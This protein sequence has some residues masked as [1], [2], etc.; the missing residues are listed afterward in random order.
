DHH[1]HRRLLV[2]IVLPAQRHRIRVRVPRLR[3]RPPI[4]RTPHRRQI[5]IRHHHQHPNITRRIHR[6][7]V[8]TR[9]IPHRLRPHH[10][11]IDT[12]H[13]RTAPPTSPPPHAHPAN[14]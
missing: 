12:N 10:I 6:Q 2:R 5:P 3:I 4:D 14:T 7:L 13:P 8:T 9:R 1:L 11:G